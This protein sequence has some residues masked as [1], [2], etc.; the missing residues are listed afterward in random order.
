VVPLGLGVLPVSRVRGQAIDSVTLGI[1]T[2]YRWRGYDRGDGVLLRTDISFALGGFSTSR[3]SDD[4]NNWTFDFLTWNPIAH[5]TTR[6]SFDQYAA[7][8][9]YGRCLSS[10]D[11]NEWG[12]RTTLMF[13]ANG[14]YLP[15]VSGTQTTEELEASFRNFTEIEKLNGKQVGINLFQYL[16]LDHDFK[17]LN[18]NYVTVGAGTYLGPAGSLSFAL[19]AS[20]SFSNWP[21][22]SGDGRSFGY[23]AAN[24]Q[25]GVDHDMT[26]KRRHISTRLNW[27]VEF[28]AA[29]I[30]AKAGMLSVRFK[31]SGPVYMF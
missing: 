19:D 2:R 9:G 12:K 27:D 24:I 17:R 18:G 8:L 11:Q 26:I 16:T 1:D 22:Q 5:R 20:A 14:Y 7:S 30:G 25:L 4:R 13:A 15:N 31:V 3:A 29:N 23:H 10:C 28:P 6:R 21:T